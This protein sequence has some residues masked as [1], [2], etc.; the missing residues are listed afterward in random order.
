MTTA[1]NS[2]AFTPAVETTSSPAPRKADRI[3]SLDVLRGIALLGMF[4]VHF[5]DN[6]IDAAGVAATYQKIVDLFFEERFWTMFG[7][8]FGIGFAIQFRRAEARG[9]SYTAKYLRR[10]AALAIFGFIAHAVFGYNVLLGYAIWGVPLLLFRK[11]S[12]RALIIALIVSATSYA[13]YDV[14]R[15]AYGVA[16]EGEQAYRAE[17]AA[18]AA[19]NR[20]FNE[21]NSKAR[22]G[23]SYPAVF[24][25]RL[26]HMKWFYAQWFTF[27][28]VNTLTLFLLGLIGLRLGI[29]D[30][31]E[32][33]RRLIVSLMVFGALSWAYSLLSFPTYDVGTV[34]G[35][36]STHLRDGFGLLRGTWLAFVYI[37]AVLLLIARNPAWLGRL[38]AFG[39]TGRMALTNYMIQI[40]I[41]DLTF[42]HYALGILITPL[43]GLVLA[44]ALFVVDVAFSKWWLARYRYGPLEWIW[45]SATYWKR[46]RLRL[47]SPQIDMIP[48]TV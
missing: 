24:A 5:K 21:E 16:T 14:T 18:T 34:R 15:A 22:D 19:K 46:Q 2:L 13:V 43:V 41:L 37:G 28:P 10:M 40:A 39:W 6:S 31:P 12:T 35:V 17:R 4:L 26:Q 42:A 47:E 36:A 23:R 3:G 20:A 11:W 44:L 25:A 45:R 30:H 27:L 1:S 38:S 7:I 33:H 32:E 48:R 9:D 29:F 8:L